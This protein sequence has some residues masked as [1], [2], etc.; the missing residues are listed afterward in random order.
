MSREVPQ[1]KYL[2]T[3]N[4]TGICD[5]NLDE[6]AADWHDDQWVIVQHGETYRLCHHDLSADNFSKTDF[7]CEISKE[8]AHILI[9]RLNLV[10]TPNSVFR[11]ARTWR[12]TYGER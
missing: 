11:L 9:G 5:L 2:K 4:L 7:K 6:V 3:Y 12:T 10:D 1:S 8:Q